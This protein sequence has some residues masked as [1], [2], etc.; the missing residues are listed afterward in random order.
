MKES[1]ATVKRSVYGCIGQNKSVTWMGENMNKR[2][3]SIYEA[4]YTVTLFNR[5]GRK[6]DSEL[7]N[8]YSTT[9]L[10]SLFT[11]FEAI[12]TRDIIGKKS[13]YICKTL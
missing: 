6:S 13:R 11:L 9:N 8:L 7:K 3:E 2:C 4:K 12:A 10:I 1:T 5:G